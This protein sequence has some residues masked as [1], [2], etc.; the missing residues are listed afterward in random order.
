MFNNNGGQGG[1]NGPYDY[2]GSPQHAEAMRFEHEQALNRERLRG[3]GQFND[4]VIF[5]ANAAWEK[6]NVQINQLKREREQLT[7]QVQELQAELNRVIDVAVKNNA[8]ADSDIQQWDEY[9]EKLKDSLEKVT[10]EKDK[11]KAENEALK[12]QS[13]GSEELSKV[14]TTLQEANQQMLTELRE[15]RRN[16][17]MTERD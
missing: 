15:L 17:E 9:T 5:G 13:S 1:G 3:N 16:N 12:K 8:I 4:G 14:I 10:D 7:F 11:L 2:I 6:A